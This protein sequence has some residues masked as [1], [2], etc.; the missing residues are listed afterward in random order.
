MRGLEPWPMNRVPCMECGDIV[1]ATPWGRA[2]SCGRTMARLRPWSHDAE[3]DDALAEWDIWIEDADLLI[4]GAKAARIALRRA[5]VQNR[6]ISAAIIFR[7][8]DEED[9]P[10]DVELPDT[11]VV[12]CADAEMDCWPGTPTTTH[13][14]TILDYAFHHQQERMMIQ[15]GQGIGRAAAACLAV[16]AS[17]SMRGFEPDSIE[18]V[19]GLRPCAIVNKRMA[20]LTDDLLQRSGALL[21]AV[22]DHPLLR[23]RRQASGHDHGRYE[24]ARLLLPRDNP[25]FGHPP[26]RLLHGREPD[27]YE[28]AWD[29][30]RLQCLL[31]EQNLWMEHDGEIWRVHQRADGAEVDR[32]DDFDALFRRHKP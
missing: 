24:L 17:R 22:D 21:K 4:V 31:A 3:S 12:A 6:P 9:R 16:L 5:E 28:P 20:K 7:A 32:D 11:C 8:D 27:T 25:L 1:S 13:I 30:R 29:A 23:A 15:C 14:Q 2:C 10:A 19:L 26:R 18:G